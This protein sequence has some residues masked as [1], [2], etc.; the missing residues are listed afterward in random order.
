MAM[1]ILLSLSGTGLGGAFGPI[2]PMG[3]KGSLLGVSGE[4][5]FPNRRQRGAVK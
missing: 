5:F 3:Q 4:I 1:V 2:W